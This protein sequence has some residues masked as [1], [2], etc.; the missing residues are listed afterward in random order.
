MEKF[1]RSTV[2]LPLLGVK[3]TFSTLFFSQNSFFISNN[4]WHRPPNAPSFCHQLNRCPKEV[5]D[6]LSMFADFVTCIKCN[7]VI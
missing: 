1:W 4:P 5:S 7:T 3:R 6:L 2:S